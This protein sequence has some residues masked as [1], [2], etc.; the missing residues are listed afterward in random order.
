MKAFSTFVLFAAV[1]A[2]AVPANADWMVDGAPVSTALGNQHN[3]IIAPDGL[4]GAI[5]MW[6]DSRSGDKVYAQRINALGITVWTPDG[7]EVCPVSS[8]QWNPALVPDGSG[9]AIVSWGDNRDTVIRVYLQ[10]IDPNGELLWTADGVPVFNV[11]RSGGGGRMVSDAA[12]GAIIVWTDFRN[13]TQNADIYAQRVNGAGSIQWAASGVPVCTLTDNQ[14]STAIDSDGASGVIV[15]WHDNRNS[16]TGNDVYA[17]RI[18]GAGVPQWTVNGVSVVV[19]PD[20]QWVSDVQYDGV[21]GA[22]LAWSDRRTGEA[23]DVY[24]QRVNGSGVPQWNAG[25]IAL[26]AAENH[27]NSSLL[28]SDDAGG[29][30]VLWTDHAGVGGP[31][32][33]AQ[34][35][36]GAGDTQWTSGGVPVCTAIGGTVW[37]TASSDGAGGIIATWMDFR[38]QEGD[39]FAQRLDGAGTPLW[40]TNGTIVSIAENYQFEPVV[41]SDSDGGAIIA[42]DDYRSGIGYDVYAQRVY[43]DGDVAAAVGRT[44][45]LPSFTLRDNSPNPFSSTTRIEFN[46]P[47]PSFLMLDVYDVRGRRVFTDRRGEMKAGWQ[48]MQF[49]G[50]DVAGQLLPSGV[51]FYR[52]ATNAGSVSD[53]MV[54]AR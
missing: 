54:I 47:E 26:T 17:Q 1:A 38:Y 50:R 11:G 32:L 30:I 37:A 2:A 35:I 34:R 29:V 3:T 48:Q 5:V 51:Y 19:A 16:A 49:N 6:E 45:H 44:G 8:M 28:A 13:G 36:D 52:V 21:G 4:G 18:N 20:G 22:F 14:Y 53:K 40:N 39:I 27:Q 7:V 25:G 41:A 43:A 9:G 42:W 10:R 15:A 23:D 31:D 12:G 46:L 24:V 33:F